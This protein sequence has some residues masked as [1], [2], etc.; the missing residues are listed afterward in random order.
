VKQLAAER[1]VLVFRDQTMDTDTQIALAKRFGPLHQH[2]G[3]EESREYVV[4]HAD[5]N[6]V[7]AKESHGVQGLCWHTDQPFVEQPPAL[8][9]LRM[10]IAPD[11][12]GDTLFAS[13]YAAYAALSE[14]MKQLLNGLTGLFTAGEQ[15][16]KKYPNSRGGESEHPLVRVHPL[17][18][19]PALYFDPRGLKSI[20]QLRTEETA[21]LLAFLKDHVAYNVA[22]QVRVRWQPNT[23]TIWDNRC[24]QHHAVWDYYPAVR[25][26]IRVTTGGERPEPY[27]VV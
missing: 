16:R 4:I 11:V 15:H 27:V 6:S 21:M 10:E 2:P 9:M 23:L 19:R 18:G 17:T 7:A 1:G 26:G 24:V 12:G 14:P 5:E 8:S 20:K 22:A 25:H 13:M 3:M